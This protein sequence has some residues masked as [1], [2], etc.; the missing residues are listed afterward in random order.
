VAVSFS[1]GAP[2]QSAFA[3]GNSR[4]LSAI[5]VTATRVAESIIALPVSI[6]IGSPGRPLPTVSLSHLSDSLNH[7]AGWCRVQS[8]QN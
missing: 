8:R 7:G 1:A 4:K 2:C 3:D 5:V 6:E